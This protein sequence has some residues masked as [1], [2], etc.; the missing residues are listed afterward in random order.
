MNN[1]LWR[2]KI[3]RR[4]LSFN[5]SVAGWIGVLLRGRQIIK[6]LRARSEAFH[7]TKLSVSTSFVAEPKGV[8]KGL[9][10]DTMGHTCATYP[11]LSRRCH[12]FDKSELKRG[13]VARGWEW[14]SYRRQASNETRNFDKN[15]TDIDVITGLV[16]IPYNHNS[17]R[18]GIACSASCHVERRRIHFRM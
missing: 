15:V 6:E 2:K 17:L 5:L 12:C 16:H 3:F 14:V 4:G 18:G 11:I 13:V 10:G 8:A 9:R 7:E 1:S